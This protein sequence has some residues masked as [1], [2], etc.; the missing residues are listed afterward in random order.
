MLGPIKLWLRDNFLD[1]FVEL[2]SF[3]SEA[4]DPNH[5]RSSASYDIYEFGDIL[6][7]CNASLLIAQS[8]FDQFSLFLRLGRHSRHTPT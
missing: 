5:I 1:I 7:I 8:H 3:N 4:A 6:A 2:P